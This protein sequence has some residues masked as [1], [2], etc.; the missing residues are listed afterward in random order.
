M[1]RLWRDEEVVAVTL[2]TEAMPSAFVWHGRTHHVER[3]DATWQID[4]DW[5]TDPDGPQGGA[6]SRR[7][8]R[9]ITRS[10]FLCDLCLDRLT[11]TWSLA[12][13]FD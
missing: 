2:D 4:T 10:G 6:V 9:L 11:Q 12:R 5:W 3:I 7:Y 13:I 8:V 1:T